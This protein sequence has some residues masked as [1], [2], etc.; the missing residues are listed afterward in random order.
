MFVGAYWSQ[1]EES[2]EA[3]AARIVAF[4]KAIGGHSKKFASW[5]GKARSRSAALR[6]P[7]ML[8]PETVASKLRVNH[9][10]ADRQPIPELGFEFS[11]WNGRDTSFSTAIGAFSR[12]V[13]NSVVLDIGGDNELG[14]EA[15]RA[16]LEEVVRAFEP[17]HAVVT[18]H[19]HL[20]RTGAKHP[21][22]AGWFTYG[23]VEGLREHSF[24]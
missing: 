5:F 10:D 13:D 6:S 4:L 12:H 20:A 9:R 21:W 7:L 18:S 22:E 2:R 15:Y 14:R 8:D 23:Q 3:A 24:R 11:V 19:E 16:L 17:E 1:R